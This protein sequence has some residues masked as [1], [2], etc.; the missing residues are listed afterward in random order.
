MNQNKIIEDLESSGKYKVVRRYEKPD[1]YHH[2]DGSEKI[3][4]IFLDVETTGLSHEI[5]KI[6][7]IALVPFEFSKDGRI[8]KIH[9]SYSC[10]ED[11]KVPLTEK[12]IALTGLT[13]E[14]L[15]G[16]SFDVDAINKVVESADLILA[17]NAEFDR[18]FVEK[19]FPVFIEKG[20]ACSQRQ[21][22]WEEEGIASLK[23]EYLAYK[24]GYFFEGH[25]AEIDC[26]ASIHL[27][28]MKLPKSENF[29]LDVLLKNARRKSYRIWAL[30]SDFEKKD[31]LKNRGYKWFP[32]G[33]GRDRSW[34]IEVDEENLEPELEYLKKEIYEREIDLPI[35]TITAFNRFSERV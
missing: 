26:Y 20:W 29:V 13:D 34:H 21:V 11:P 18:K 1:Y 31:I 16:K 30:G 22:P 7:E 15:A 4:G 3:K 5:D 32:G 14:M 19:R 2:D 6:I 24:F 27:L 28:S 17:H 25:R 35:D 33:E 8:F 9:D 12:I 23:L 10:L